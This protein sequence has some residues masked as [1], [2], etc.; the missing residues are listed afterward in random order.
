MP[1]QAQ[2]ISQ[3]YIKI[4][5]EDAPRGIM[6]NLISIEVDDSLNLPD[7]FTIH[8]RD[9]RLEWTDSET[10]A[11][12]KEIEISAGGEN[13]QVKLIT[14]EITAVET[15]FKSGAG[16]TLIVRGYDQSHRLNRGRQTKTFN[17]VTD[18][19]I[20]TRIA[21]E[22]GLRTDIDSTSEVYQYVL[23]D[24][25]TNLEFLQSRAERIGF[26]LLV[27]A[28]TLNF[29]RIPDEG[30]EVP[31]LEFGVNL[32]EFNAH[33]TTSR[34]TS[35]VEVRGWDPQAKREIVGR[36]TRAQDMPEVGEQRQGGQVAEAAFG[37][38]GKEVVVNHAIGTQ[39][40]AD[41]L[42]QSI[43][44]EMGGDFIQSEGVCAGNPKVCAG[45][46]VELK[47]LSDRFTGRY[48]I[49]HS[50]H[51]YS[52]GGYTTRFT[53]S[54]RHDNTLGQLV[55]QQNGGGGG[56]GS[57]NGSK[58]NSVVVG[59]VTNNQDSD[60]MGR[61]KVKFPW[62]ADGVESNWARIA[63]PMG[64]QERG[65]VFLPEVNDE[66]LV[67][68]E[69]GDMNRPYVLGALWNGVDKPPEKNQD[70]QNNIR[71]IRSRSGHEIIF[72][73]NETARRE[74]L[75]IHSN[76]GH[77]ILLDDSSGQEKIEIKDKTGNNVIKVDSV[78]NAI[79]IESTMK[80]NIK[81]QLIEVEAQGMMTL[82]AGGTLTIQ[83]ALVKIN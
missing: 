42:A 76:A 40:E 10:I 11:I 58:N 77:K 19:D 39:A 2:L 13:G 66:V 35:E 56:G 73:D 16:A 36:A 1:P 64:G 55:S 63:S 60:Q 83:G 65:M 24:N 41:T 27:E 4:D 30:D 72:D 48:R 7:M 78:Q 18:S 3:F 74:K 79:S 17:Q 20:A 15:N 22:L 80:L 28:D 68:F 69:Q 23:Q 26:R 51:R 32:S 25:Q 57:K 53:I 46:M 81:S 62:L 52:A 14:G 31:T 47:S 75:E 70:G 33:L 44:E 82:K 37:N 29:K 54:G 71:K 45:A 38:S 9:P 5:G 59:I 50:L 67:A 34:Q 21:H 43:C 12:G 8:L 61:V 6:D 49:T